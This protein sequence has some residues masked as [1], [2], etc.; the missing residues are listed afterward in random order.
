M[1]AMETLRQ[2]KEQNYKIYFTVVK[3]NVFRG[4]GLTFNY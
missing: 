4:Y 1:D 3:P 2:I